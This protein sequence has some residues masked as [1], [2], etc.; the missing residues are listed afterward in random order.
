MEHIGNASGRGEVA[1]V[2]AKNAPD[3]GGGSILV[4]SRGFNDHCHPAWSI[5]LV[6]DL[7]E[8]LRVVAFTGAAFDCPLDIIVRHALG[9]RRLDRAPQTWIAIGIAAAGLRSDGD[10]LRQFAEDLAAFRVNHAFETLDLRP[11]AMSRHG[12]GVTFSLT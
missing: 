3:L 8:V 12:W 2:F 10:F 5:A 4:I 6:N 1:I 11:L 7:V 9:P